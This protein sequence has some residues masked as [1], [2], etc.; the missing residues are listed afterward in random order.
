MNI[1]FAGI[2][3]LTVLAQTCS[4]KSDSNIPSCIQARI[5][6]IRQQPKWNPPASVTEYRYQGRTVYLFSSNCCDQ[7]NEVVDAA[8]NYICAPSG[9]M[10]GKGDRKCADFNEKAEKIKVVWQDER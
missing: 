6:A 1:T 8:C 10:T 9:G 2:F 4:K 3:L 7:Y 5:D